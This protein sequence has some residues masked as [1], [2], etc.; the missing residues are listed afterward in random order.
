MWLNLLKRTLITSWTSWTTI[1]KFIIYTNLMSSWL[2]KTLKT[3]KISLYTSISRFST[4][5]TGSTIINT[6]TM[7]TSSKN[8]KLL[9]HKI[10]G[11]FWRYTLSNGLPREIWN[12]PLSSSNLSKICSLM[13]LSRSLNHLSWNY[14]IL[15]ILTLLSGSYNCRNQDKTF[16]RYVFRMPYNY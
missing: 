9:S 12:L 7:I 2:T 4:N 15:L 6:A 5:Q 8:R 16:W 11:N 1:T 3:M 10:I 13:R 14:I